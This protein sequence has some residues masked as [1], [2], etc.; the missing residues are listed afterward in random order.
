MA[1]KQE[2]I[3]NDTAENNVSENKNNSKKFKALCLLL[4]FVFYAVITG[5]LAL[6]VWMPDI[7]KSESENRMLA[8]RP[9]P[10]FSSITDGS[11]MED[12]ESYMTDQFPFRDLIVSTKSYIE[13]LSGKRKINNIYIGDDGYLLEEQTVPDDAQIDTITSAIKEFSVKNKDIK[14]AVAISPNATQVLKNKLP[15]NVELYN[16]KEQLDRIKTLIGSENVSWIDCEDILTSSDDDTQIFYR[17]DHH[18]TTRAAYNVFDSIASGWNM[19]A[20]KQNYQ[21][22]SV[23][24]SFQGTLSSSSGVSDITDIIEICVP[25]NSKET[26]VVEYESQQ[27]KKSTLFDKDK[28]NQKNQYEVF[29]GGNFDKIIISTTADT[30]DTL[31]IF[32]DS[33]ANCMI[34]MFTPFFSEIVVIDPRYFND[35]LDDVML[36]YNFTHVLFLYNLNTFLEDASLADVLDY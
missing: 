27:L 17:T 16:Q 24:D 30:N 1:K 12:F 21:F 29:F 5:V 33:Y 4:N 32:K 23:S 14:K 25:Y 28:L 31:L 20:E 7:E 19:D 10:T 15:Y 18:W 8:Q 34:P 9:T 3:D 36:E 11:F 22:F 2:N 13:R 35:M 26:Y 6:C